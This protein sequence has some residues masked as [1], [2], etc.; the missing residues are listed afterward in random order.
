MNIIAEVVVIAFALFLLGATAV[1]FAKPALIER[2]FMTM[3]NSAKAHY[4][5]QIVRLLVGISLVV[6]SPRMWQSKLFW[7]AGWMI[8]VS[9]TALIVT[10]WR[11]HFRFGERIRP[12]LIKHMKLYAVGVFVFGGLLLYGVFAGSAA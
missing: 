2:L 11:W 5:E 9:S 4:T 6:A 10:P 12:R 3:A 7:L 1:T 8:I